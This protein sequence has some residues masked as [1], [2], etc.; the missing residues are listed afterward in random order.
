GEPGASPEVRTELDDDL[1]DEALRD[2]RIEERRRALLERDRQREEARHQSRWDHEPKHKLGPSREARR[3]KKLSPEA[4]GD[5]YGGHR[6]SE[7]PEEAYEA[8]GAEGYDD[9]LHDPRFAARDLDHFEEDEDPRF[10]MR[11]EPD[12]FMEDEDAGVRREPQVPRTPLPAAVRG[13]LTEAQVLMIG[14]E[15]LARPRIGRR[16]SRR[17]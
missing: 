4:R 14:S 8:S 3:A 1:H 16:R 15:I 6:A 7:N 17:A 13:R 12:P 9:D 10:A 2:P 5:S 11:D